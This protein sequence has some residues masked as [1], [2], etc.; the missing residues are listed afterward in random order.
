MAADI[1]AKPIRSALPKNGRP[2]WPVLDPVALHGLAGD[3][4][5]TLE[6]TTEADPAA[7]LA[8]F[9]TAFGNLAGRDSYVQVEGDQHPPGLYAVIV[10]ETSKARKGTSWGRVRGIFAEAAPGW[11][12]T[13]ATSGAVS[14]EGLLWDV[15]DAVYR[16]L[17]PKDNGPTAEDLPDELQGEAVDPGV[18]DKR[19]L[20]LSAEFAGLLKA[21]ER[22]DNTLSATLRELWDTGTHRTAAKNMPARTTGA[23]TSL[24]AHV[25]A[26]ELR[27]L[28][29]QTEM[30]NGFANRFLYVCA[31]RSKLLP[32][33]PVPN[34]AV[35]AELGERVREAATFARAG[36]VIARDQGARELWAAEYERLSAGRPGLLGAVTN[37]AEAQVTRLSLIYALL[38]S[39]PVITVEHLG[40]ALALW[41]YCFDSATWIFGS[42]LGDPLADR[43]RSALAQN[44]DGLTR[45][46]IRSIVGGRTEASQ[47]DLALDLL[48]RHDI[49]RV[50]TEP[51]NG[52][53][54]ERWS[55]EK[56]E[57]RAS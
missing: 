56:R 13:C 32:E 30:A 6:P 38:D 36:H 39:S 15:R 47:I 44:P 50:V 27:R 35:L 10:G 41:R 16:P 54:V 5:R 2:D 18:A 21:V 4:V 46:E 3:V 29:S 20:W 7:L 12:K 14:G 11:L 25:T 42:Q 52:R 45:T 8:Q 51:T 34:P 40:A 49:A 55:V 57:Q 1:G 23:H 19:R 26:D 28:L 17:A 22:R 24:I 48:R 33:S 37:R 43:L 53:P 31:R 9:L